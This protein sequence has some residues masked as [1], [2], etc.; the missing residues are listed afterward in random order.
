M[1]ATILKLKFT[2]V[3]HQLRR[4]WWRAL[5]LIGGAV[6]SLTLVPMVFWAQTW[7]G[8]ETSDVR[9]TILVIFAA[10]CTAGWMVVP[11]LV[12]GLEDT[13]D[14]GRF[15]TLG[16]DARRIAPGLI[17]AAFLTVPALF[18]MLVFTVLSGAWRY[19]SGWTQ[20]VAVVGGLLTVATM[21]LGA[22]VA[23]AWSSRAVN[24]RRTR[25]L[26]FLAIGLGVAVVG[27]VTWLV[28]RDGLESGLESTVPVLGEWLGRTPLGAGMQAPA[29]WAAGDAWGAVWRLLVVAGTAVLLAL[30]WKDS[31][32]H[33]LVHPVHRGGGR[34]RR[35]DAVMAGAGENNSGWWRASGPMRAVRSRMLISW[36]TDA[37]YIV[38]ALGVVA[39]PVVFFA[40]LMPVLSLDPR[41]AFA[42]P[43][44]LASS[45]G[46]GRHNDVALD[47]SGL[48]LDIVSGSRGRD[49]MMGRLQ[50]VLIWAA[51]ATG[52]AVLGVLVWSGRWAD[53][54]GLVGAAA[55]TLGATLGVSAVC[56][57]VF[58]Y[59][60][61]GPGE[62]PFGAEVGSL[63]ASLLAQVVSSLGMLVVLPLVTVP[64]VLA[65]TVH[66]GWGWVALVTGVVIGALALVWGA[67]VAGAL[68]DRRSGRLIGAVT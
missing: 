43:L 53:A 68:Y 4:E 60:A 32:A 59:R 46:W 51:P 9:G 56:A 63:G 13:L 49:I 42:A 65:L 64:L 44:L 3:A 40:I 33:A 5:L 8:F 18:F 62:N 28:L 54:P 67:R 58:P 57:V 55:G 1:V 50:A 6:W 26:L 66:S 34:Q 52:V 15:A 30:A 41:W 31:I 14:P 27:S 11:L 35:V 47:S 19:E 12:T 23:V 25:V 7:L 17:I 24:E 2:T 39:L 45:I 61:P 48:W 20:A 36:S 38:A 10:V 16:V 37:R 22:R 29:V 21:V